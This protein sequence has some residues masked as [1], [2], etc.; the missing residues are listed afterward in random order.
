[1]LAT[2]SFYP[3]VKA[4]L[5]AA[6]VSIEMKDISLAARILAV[7]PEYLNENQ[8]ITDALAGARDDLDQQ[9]QLARDVSDPGEFHPVDHVLA[10]RGIADPSSLIEAVKLAARLS[11]STE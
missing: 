6:N 5:G 10:G 8:R 1:M 11:E 9:P 2:H 4:F 3:I 7:F